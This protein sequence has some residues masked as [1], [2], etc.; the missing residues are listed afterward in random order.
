MLNFNVL[1]TFLF[2]KLIVLIYLISFVYQFYKY[3]KCYHTVCYQRTFK[4][5]LFAYLLLIRVPIHILNLFTLHTLV[6]IIIIII[7]VCL[8]YGSPIL[9][10]A[11]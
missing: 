10:L 4:E 1:C 6:L 9:L 7:L 11:F 3:Y 8:I 2:H 5:T